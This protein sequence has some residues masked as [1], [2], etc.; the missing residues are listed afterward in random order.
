ME[1]KLDLTYLKKLVAELEIMVEGAEVQRSK[2]VEGVPHDYLIELNKVNGVLA[3]VAQEAKMLTGDVAQITRIVTTPQLQKLVSQDL[4]EDVPG[5]D[6]FGG[7]F[8]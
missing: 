5:K 8:N 7:S 6:P 1:L 2:K 4:Y 3:G